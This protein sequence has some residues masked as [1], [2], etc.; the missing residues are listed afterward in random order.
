M[1]ELH[2][3]VF[4]VDTHEG[5]A[6]RIAY[7]QMMVVKAL[8]YFATNRGE[9]WF[10]PVPAMIAMLI[11]KASYKRATGMEPDFLLANRLVGAQYPAKMLQSEYF[12]WDKETVHKLDHTIRALPGIPHD[13]CLMVRWFISEEYS[14]LHPNGLAG[15]RIASWW[16]MRTCG[17]HRDNLRMYLQKQHCVEVEE[18]IM[19]RLG[20]SFAQ[21]CKEVG[22]EMG[23]Y[24]VYDDHIVFSR[25]DECHPTL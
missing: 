11:V 25:C 10:V 23:K 17:A 3:P 15:I 18:T 6:L 24:S 22:I 2:D 4:T 7:F 9:H 16:P 19:P 5:T 13:M 14:I 8:L 1:K 21:W 20:E 12:W